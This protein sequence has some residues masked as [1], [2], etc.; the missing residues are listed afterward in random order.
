MP[1]YA[2]TQIDNEMGK[3]RINN[4]RKVCGKRVIDGSSEKRKDGR[5]LLR[6]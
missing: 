4:G 6:L 5:K 2:G 1:I 3:E